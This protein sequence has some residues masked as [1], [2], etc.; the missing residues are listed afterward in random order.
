MAGLKDAMKE[1]QRERAD[2]AHA[3][4]SDDTGKAPARREYVEIPIDRLIPDTSQPR[5]HFDQEELQ[6]LADNIS[7]IGLKQ[8]ILVG[9]RQEDGFWPI[10]DGERRWRAAKLAGRPTLEAVVDDLSTASDK[11]LI[12]LAANVQR[13]DNTPFE[14]GVALQEIQARTNLDWTSIAQQLG[15]SKSK[16][17]RYV[18][19]AK[20]ASKRLRER[21]E[22]AGVQDLDAVY[23]LVRLEQIQPDAAA[24]LL[25]RHQQAPEDVKAHGGLR[26]AAA[27]ALAGATRTKKKVSRKQTKPKPGR[28]RPKIATRAAIEHRGDAWLLTIETTGEVTK[29]KLSDNLAR[30]LKG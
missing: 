11:A 30:A 8:P 22:A 25:R 3:G 13:A 24:E 21:L 1:T 17:S 2:I 7:A 14:I 5:Q 4:R 6:G 20:K 16:V 23:N 12:Q 28:G 18:S 15:L 29:F 9:P 19:I 10:I 27:E 26:K